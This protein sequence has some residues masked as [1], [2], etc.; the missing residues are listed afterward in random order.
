MGLSGTAKLPR[1]RP[2]ENQ[3]LMG[4][5]CSRRADMPMLLCLI[6]RLGIRSSPWIGIP[7]LLSDLPSSR[8]IINRFS[9][10]S[11]SRGDR[12]KTFR[13]NYQRMTCSN[14]SASL[15]VLSTSVFILLSAW[16]LL[17]SKHAR[18]LSSRSSCQRW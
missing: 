5:F 10:K 13:M 8:R 12:L 11:K 15:G 16:P 3:N 1:I 9:M 7:F 2:M 14:I 6:Q 17:P 18:R 4:M